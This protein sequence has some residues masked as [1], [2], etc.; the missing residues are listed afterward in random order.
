MRPYDTCITIAEKH[1]TLRPSIGA[2]FR[3]MEKYGD[4]PSLSQQTLAGSATAIID[5][6]TTCA[7]EFDA[8]RTISALIE[9]QPIDKLTFGVLPAMLVH[10]LANLSGFDKHRVS[11]AKVE[12]SST[13][14]ISDWAKHYREL[15][16]I[17]TGFLRMSPADAWEACPI[18]IMLAYDKRVEILQAMNGVVSE[19][20][21]RER[22]I[23]SLMDTEPDPDRKAKL[24]GKRRKTGG[25]R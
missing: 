10:H 22:D 23:N 20:A 21:K 14:P 3:L 11:K 12:P 9:K 17:A 8:N 5:I 4:M 1:L 16:G 2:A 25:Q 6:V 18:E 13:K 19:D 24:L 15:Y 7:L